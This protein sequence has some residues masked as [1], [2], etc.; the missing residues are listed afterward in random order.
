MSILLIELL[1]RA[2]GAVNAPCLLL[3]QINGN[4]DTHYVAALKTLPAHA[5][6][7]MRVDERCKVLA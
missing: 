3:I 2:N 7:K 6:Y 5:G 1:V 4:K